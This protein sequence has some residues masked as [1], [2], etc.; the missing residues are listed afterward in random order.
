[1]T[2]IKTWRAVRTDGNRWHV[3]APP[4]KEGDPPRVIASDLDEWDANTIAVGVKMLEHESHY[5]DEFATHNEYEHAKKLQGE[6]RLLV[7]A[8]RLSRVG[9]DLDSE[10]EPDEP[11]EPEPKLSKSEALWKARREAWAKELLEDASRRIAEGKT[12]V[13][14]IKE[15][16]VAS[17]DAFVGMVLRATA[18]GK[19]P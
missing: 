5:L 18:K 3:E 12:P 9:L 17:V 11:P 15:T 7:E 10:P 13:P 2:P 14:S 8:G 1:M 16:L 19:K 4:K 6:Q